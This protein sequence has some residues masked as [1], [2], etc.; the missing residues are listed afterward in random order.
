MSAIQSSPACPSFHDAHFAWL[1]PRFKVIVGLGGKNGYFF[2]YACPVI[3]ALVPL[4]PQG[5]FI[6]D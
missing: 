4:P 2:A 5:S 3:G 1:L 6:E